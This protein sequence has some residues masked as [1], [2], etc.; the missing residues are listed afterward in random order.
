MNY[1]YYE[2]GKLKIKILSTHFLKSDIHFTMYFKN[3]S[4]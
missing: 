2:K 4:R 3:G 1:F